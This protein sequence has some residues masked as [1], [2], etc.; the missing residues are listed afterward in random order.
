[1]RARAVNG[2]TQANQ[3]M[4][5][6]RL[7]AEGLVIVVNCWLLSLRLPLSFPFL[8][9]PFPSDPLPWRGTYK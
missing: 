9:L 6:P 2:C 5:T 7:D 3:E 4:K 8:C 1:M